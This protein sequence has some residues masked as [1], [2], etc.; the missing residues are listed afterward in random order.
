[1]TTADI[2]AAAVPYAVQALV[3]IA[4][5]TWAAWH[6]YRAWRLRMHREWE[7]GRPS[8]RR[9]LAEVRRERKRHG[10][11]ASFEEAA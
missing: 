3:A 4:L 10:V 6:L 5:G 9:V 11:P 8:Y 2:I 7:A 1:M